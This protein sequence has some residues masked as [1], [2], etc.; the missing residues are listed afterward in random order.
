MVHDWAGVNWK[1]NKSSRQGSCLQ[2]SWHL[3]MRTQ[4]WKLF[5]F[6]RERRFGCVEKLPVFK[7]WQLMFKKAKH[8]VCQT[9]HIYVPYL[10]CSHQFMTSG[11]EHYSY[12]SSRRWWSCLHTLM[13]VWG[14]HLTYPSWNCHHRNTA[15][16]VEPQQK[17][18]W[19]GWCDCW[20][21]LT[22]Y[23]GS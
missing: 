13:L 5:C 7:H 8:L 19:T 17:S 14:C 6:M 15:D 3:W 18:K 22:D 2:I 4:H 16:W 10:V 11:M 23:L 12:N 21:F 20:C 9:Q 1:M